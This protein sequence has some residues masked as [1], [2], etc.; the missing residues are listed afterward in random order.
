[1][2]N[3]FGNCWG[4]NLTPIP[5]NQFSSMHLPIGVKIIVIGDIGIEVERPHGFGGFGI[6]A[7]LRM[8]NGG[9]NL[10]NKLAL[11]RDDNGAM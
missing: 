1:M 6:G 10:V 9:L 3:K 8:T 2:S 11:D 5:F 7:K 4:G